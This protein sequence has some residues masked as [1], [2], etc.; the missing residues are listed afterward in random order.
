MT[1]NKNLY[2]LN[3]G[4]NFFQ[5]L[6]ICSWLNPPMAELPE[7]QLYHVCSFHT[8]EVHFWGIKPKETILKIKLCVQICSYV[9]I[10]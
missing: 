3:T 9:L 5:I 1:R 6:L 4:N 10:C 8:N 7:G 2:M